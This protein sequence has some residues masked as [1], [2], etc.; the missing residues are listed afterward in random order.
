MPRRCDHLNA[1]SSEIEDKGSEDID[2]SFT[3]VAPAR[4][5]LTQFQRATE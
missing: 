2:V 4:T 5:H 1:E 3:G